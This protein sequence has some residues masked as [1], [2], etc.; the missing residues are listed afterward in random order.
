L[1]DSG[2][3]PLEPVA[4]ALARSSHP[5]R[6]PPAA[7]PAP[8]WVA[9]VFGVLAVGILPW[10]VWLGLSLPARTVSERWNLAWVGFDVAL[11]L[12]LAGTAL[13]AYRRS[14]WVVATATAAATLLICDAWFDVTTSRSRGELMVALGQA[15]LME[16]PLAGI[17][18][19]IAR[20]AEQVKE[21]TTVLLARHAHRS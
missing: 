12:A 13:A 9:P 1:G 4:A 17:C 6:R 5:S 16:L 20:H 7:A 2:P 11:F 21:R 8:R 10:T 14:T 3:T 15:V 19:W 18:L